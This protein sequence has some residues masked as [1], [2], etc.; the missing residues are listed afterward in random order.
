MLWDGE[1]C[2]G[3]GVSGTVL[4]FYGPK[5]HWRAEYVFNQRGNYKFGQ[6]LTLQV[7]VQ[8]SL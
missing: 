3:M 1:R 5:R 4:E 6:A 8:S 7:E 2:C